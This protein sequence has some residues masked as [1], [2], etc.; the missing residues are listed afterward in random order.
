VI[1]PTQQDTGDPRV[2]EVLHSL[3]AL[4]AL[5]VSEQVAVFEAAHAALREAL[6]GPAQA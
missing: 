3:A 2:D 5:P 6:S 1:E 4:D